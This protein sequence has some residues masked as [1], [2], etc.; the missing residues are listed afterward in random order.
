MEERKRRKVVLLILSAGSLI[1][2]AAGVLRGEAT[3]I[4]LKGINI[5]LAC[6]GIG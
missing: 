2:I 1:L 3:Q 6:I 4:Y 5:C